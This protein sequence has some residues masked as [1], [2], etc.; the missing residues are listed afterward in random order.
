MEHSLEEAKKSGQLLTGLF[1]VNLKNKP[2]GD[3]LNI[4]EKP[5]AHLTEKELRPDAAAL[6]KILESFG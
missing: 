2:L 1:Y 6:A 5:L 3:T 4:V